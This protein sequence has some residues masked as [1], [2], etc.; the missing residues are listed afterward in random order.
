MRKKL[1]NIEGSCV[2]NSEVLYVKISPDLMVELDDLAEEHYVT[3]SDIVRI[4][5]SAAIGHVKMDR[6]T[7]SS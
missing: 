1:S 3:R 7:K 4:L 2:P 6:L 5:L